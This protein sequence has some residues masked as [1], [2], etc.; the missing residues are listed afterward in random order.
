M[1]PLDPLVHPP[2][3]APGLPARVHGGPDTVGVPRFDFST[4][5]N[6]CGPCPPA[7]VAVQQADATRYPEPRYTALRHALA[8][9]HGVAPGRILM[10]GS[11]SE[12]IFRLTAWVAR[13]GGATV[14]L[15]RHAYGD[16]AQAAQAWGLGLT[17][18][19]AQASLVWACEPSSPL[20]QAHLPWPAWLWP[21]AT[22][23]GS[24]DALLSRHTEAT[25][26]TSFS[27][28]G[29]VCASPVV[30]LDCAYAPLRLS[31]APSLSAA[32]RDQIWQ[33]FSPNKS[34]G[35][36]GVRAAY[37]IAPAGA[38]ATVQAL[39]ALAP[40]WLLG[41]HGVALL[42][43]WVTPQVQTWLGESLHTLR[44]WKARQIAMLTE[45]GWTCLPSDANFFC[46]RPAPELENLA[47]GWTAALA[48]LRGQ[49][50]KLR[51]TASFGLPGH[52]RLGVLP[53][54]AQDALRAA[55]QNS[56]R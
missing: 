42:H 5:S 14:C 36:T 2:T 26:R 29:C 50:I 19:P 40:S 44:D 4:N 32:Q 8:D 12:C 9:F 54:A 45:L 1:K 53:P 35:L 7:L 30:V 18:D 48:H 22:C 3:L 16:Y 31:G 24:D 51:D 27:A 41:A 38:E 25:S 47:A 23:A 52:A 15:P 49:G 33:L 46:A 34:L 11:A 17:H 55:W 10:A 43:A 37:A 28:N 21:D 39:D 56:G 13:Q 6:A 20:G